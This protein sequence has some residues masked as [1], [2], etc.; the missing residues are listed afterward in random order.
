M[1]DHHANDYKLIMTGNSSAVIKYHFRDSLVGRK[2]VYELYPLNFAE[3]L[4]FKGEDRLAHAISESPQSIPDSYRSALDRYFEEFIIFGAYPKVVKARTKAEKWDILMDIAGSCILKDN[5]DLFRIEKPQKLN[6]LVQYLCINIG[7]ELNINNLSNEVGLH[8]QTTRSYLDILEE[9]Y[10]IK[11]LKPYHRNLS[12][13]LR[14]MTKLYFVDTGIRN[15]MINDLNSL[16]RRSD[17]GELLENAIHN[18]LFHYRKQGQKLRYWQTRNRQEI[19]FIIEGTGSLTSI[20]TKYSQA[21]T[22][23]FTAFQTAYPHA[24]CHVVSFKNGDGIPAWQVI[25][26]I[27]FVL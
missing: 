11:R 1:V 20:E 10:V 26:V 14:K 23:S 3:F 2:A 17:R 25:G 27:S 18:M 21:R 19:D 24:Q 6:H 22:S 5:R 9:C 8:N 7:K 16:D 12:T 15:I 4:I 13:E